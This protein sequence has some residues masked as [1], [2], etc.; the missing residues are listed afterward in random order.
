MFLEKNASN[1]EVL[2][3]NFSG[4]I[5]LI[6]PLNFPLIIIGILTDASTPISRVTLSNSFLLGGELISLPTIYI[7]HL[8]G[9]CSTSITAE[10]DVKPGSDP[11]SINL[12]S[13][14]SVPI[15]IF[16]SDDL[17]VADINI[18]SLTLMDAQVK[19]A[20]KSG[21]EKCSASD[22]NNDGHDDLVCHFDTLGLDL[23]GGDTVATV[24]GELNDETP[25]EGSDSVSIVKDG[26]I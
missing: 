4:A 23:A 22:I 17:D 3:G 12:C 26:C 25:L 16:G 20:G 11:N 2:L 5:P 10:I 6:V 8:L 24:S 14:G 18:S 9:S 21:K 7:A 15:A 19:L 13:N 1:V